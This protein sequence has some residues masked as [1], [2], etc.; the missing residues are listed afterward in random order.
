MYTDRII[1]KAD[2]DNASTSVVVSFD[3]AW[4]ARI[5]AGAFSRIIRKRV[6]VR[7]VPNWLYFHVNAPKSAICARAE[8]FSVETL[9]E[10]FALKLGGP[11]ALTA[12]EI[13]AYIQPAA[14]VGCYSIGPVEVPLREV[15]IAELSFR[16]VYHPPQSFF[17]LSIEGKRF[18]DQM[19]SWG[20]PH[21]IVA[22][23]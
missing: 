5:R 16:L 23:G 7:M 17:V 1:A 19:C 10:E 9:T 18:I 14:S 21:S 2:L 20:E 13:S 11:L 6:P 4:Y 8:V 15:T 12:K 22:R 3:S